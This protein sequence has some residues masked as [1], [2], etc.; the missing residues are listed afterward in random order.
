MRQVNDRLQRTPHLNGKKVACECRDGLLRLRGQLK[1]YYHKR[2]AQGI[3]RQLDG[4]F[5]L[6]NEIEVTAD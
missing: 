5:D 2:V 6:V 4:V 3:V 1:S